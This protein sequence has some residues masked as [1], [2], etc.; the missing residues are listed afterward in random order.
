[1]RM[2]T[3]TQAI[4]MQQIDNWRFMY[5]PNTGVLVLGRQYANTQSLIASHAE[6]LAEAKITRD[7]DDFVRGWI[8]TGGDYPQGIIHFAPCVDAR[9]A[10][11]FNRAFCVLEMFAENGALPQTVIRG[12]GNR[13][14]QPLS[15]IIY[16]AQQAERRPSVLGQ[17][18]TIPP[19]GT[20]KRSKNNP[21]ER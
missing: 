19:K 1:M 21:F 18:K 12:F 5:N 10:N 9:N 17:L 2:D 15:S 7:Y 4:D 16:P 3:R 11:L 6:E 13:W 20:G 8:G 14:E